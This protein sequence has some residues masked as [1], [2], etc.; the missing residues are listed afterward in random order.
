MGKKI[1]VLRS[2]EFIGTLAAMIFNLRINGGDPVAKLKIIT[3]GGAGYRYECVVSR[4]ED[5]MF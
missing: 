4:E 1:A 5:E 2:Y 3:G